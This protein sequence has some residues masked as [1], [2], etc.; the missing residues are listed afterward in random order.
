MNRMKGTHLTKDGS[1]QK[2]SV[3]ELRTYFSGGSVEL[4]YIGILKYY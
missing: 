4:S 1:H 3:A 2:N